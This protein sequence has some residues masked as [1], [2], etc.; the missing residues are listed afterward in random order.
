MGP[1]GR[2]LARSIGVLLALAGAVHV[3]AVVPPAQVEQPVAPT[4]ADLA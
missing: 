3:T 1:P 2:S 4:A